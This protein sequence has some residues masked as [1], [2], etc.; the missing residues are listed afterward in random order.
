MLL[1][2]TNGDIR[3][4]REL[5]CG[6]NIHDRFLLA[7]ELQLILI[8][9]NLL[10]WFIIVLAT[11]FES[12]I[13][14]HLVYLF[15]ASFEGCCVVPVFKT[16]QVLCVIV[17]CKHNKV[18]LGILIS[19]SWFIWSRFKSIHLWMLIIEKIILSVIW[20]VMFGKHLLRVVESSRLNLIVHR[21]R[22]WEVT[23]HF[24]RIALL[25]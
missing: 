7:V 3:I 12:N 25:L 6:E 11:T 19:S 2:R 13:Q 1:W 16:S 21:P 22:H 14:L 15:S 4:L 18:E 5:I 23:I 17:I 20:L 9:K 24:T 8:V 10:L